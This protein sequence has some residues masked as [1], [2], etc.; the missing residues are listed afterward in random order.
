MFVT[1]GPLKKAVYAAV[2][3]LKCVMIIIAD[4]PSIRIIH[5]LLRL[6]WQELL[7]FKA[8]PII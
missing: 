1:G 7:Q 4:G 3:N 2:T 6:L 5:N 8:R